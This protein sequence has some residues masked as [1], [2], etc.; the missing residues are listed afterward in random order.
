MR[1]EADVVIVAGTDGTGD[2][3]EEGDYI[4]LNEG[5]DIVFASDGDDLI[6]GGGG[7]DLV[8]GNAGNDTLYGGDYRAD[9]SDNDT[10]SYEFATGAVRVNLHTGRASGADGNDELYGFE[11][12]YGSIHDDIVWGD[13]GANKLDGNDGD[14]II[15]AREG[16][17]HVTGGDG[18]DRIYAEAHADGTLLSPQ[19]R[20]TGFEKLLGGSGDDTI[21]GSDGDDRIWTG[22]DDDIVFANS[23]SDTIV[24]GGGQ[25]D[26]DQLSYAYA[27][28]FG[29][30]VDFNTK[31]TK[32]RHDG[33]VDLAYEI[34]RIIGSDF[35]DTFTFFAS[36]WATGADGDDT[37]KFRSVDN[38]AQGDG[39][40]DTA[41]FSDYASPLEQTLDGQGD[42]LLVDIERLLGSVHADRLAGSDGNDV[43]AGD[44]GADRIVD[45]AGSDS[46]WGGREGGNGDGYQDTFVFNTLSGSNATI[47]DFELRVDRVDVSG[48][49]VKSV[50]ELNIFHRAE[51]TVITT[52]NEGD[53]EIVLKDIIERID[54]VFDF[55]T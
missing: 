17:D 4:L 32:I 42:N 23:G 52:Y 39:G 11:N 5:N 8:V 46:Y 28:R 54:H 55:V 18:N 30:E 47:H 41:D 37:F 13:D 43:I 9:E 12:V 22:S 51:D 53:G 45:T 27:E 49:G 20:P 33:D 40:F 50:D 26:Y 19:G 25:G 7:D 15:V 44:R 29:I 1:R 10:V 48:M 2:G 31:T 35:G 21:Y 38:V 16:I 36:G 24:G 34:D 14:D 6:E 3:D